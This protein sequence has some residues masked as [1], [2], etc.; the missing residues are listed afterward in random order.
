MFTSKSKAKGRMLV[1]AAVVSGACFLVMPNAR[2]DIIEVEAA[3]SCPG[4]VGGGLCIGLTP[5]DLNTLISGGIN[6]VSGT[7]KFVVTDTTG[8]FSFT[9]TG[10]SGDNGSCQINGG[11]KSFFNAC[12]GVN[13]DGT[14]FSLGHDD[15]NHPGMD[16]PTVIT[17]TA[18]PGQCTVANPCTFDLGFVSWQGLGT[19]ATTV[20]EPGTLSLLAT[21]LLGLMCFARRNLDS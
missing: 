2:A 8:S 16:P 7:E 5:F 10:S 18:L 4:S 19:S 12:T 14:T 9:Y 3:T 21:G 17:F 15:T 11:A 20:P 1:A 13:A 6:N